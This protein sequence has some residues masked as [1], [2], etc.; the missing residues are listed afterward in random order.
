MVSGEDTNPTPL[1]KAWFG[2]A[3]ISI[4][5]GAFPPAG[6]YSVRSDSCNSRSFLDFCWWSRSSSRNPSGPV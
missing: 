5:A 6:S 3:G 2:V 4:W 1:D